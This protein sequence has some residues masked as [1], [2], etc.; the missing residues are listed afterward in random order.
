MD[1]LTDSL[2]DA[3][4]DDPELM[5]RLVGMAG[6]FAVDLVVALIILAATFWLARIL[7]N[8]VKR[9]LNRLSPLGETDLTLTNF[10]GSVVRYGILIVGLIAVLAQLGVQTTSILAV[11]GAAS[12]AIGL[13]MQGT[14]GNVAAGVMLLLLRPYRVGD[15]VELAGRNGNVVALDLFITTLDA[16][17]GLRL[18]IPNG[19][20]ISDVMVNYTVSGKRRIQLD[21]G[22]DYE[23]DLDKALQV[24]LDTAAAD[25]RILRDPEPWVKVT[26]LADSSVICSIRFWVES[27]D[28]VAAGPDMVKKCKHAI[29]AAGLSFPYPQQVEMSR[30]QARGL[31]PLGEA[32]PDVD[33]PGAPAGTGPAKPKRTRA[34]RTDR[35]SKQQPPIGNDEG[36]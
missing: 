18:T 2:I 11:L 7:S 19:Q 29:E 14:L 25:E 35:A 13:A 28:F 32:A 20:I 15:F 6:R 21:F 30:A 16:V 27:E 24:L 12:L 8:L 9:A 23:D 34:S 5:N 3:F 1:S 33:A 36:E 17:D 26:S 10:I 31:A 4:P 22:V